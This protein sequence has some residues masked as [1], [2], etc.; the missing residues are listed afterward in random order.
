MERPKSRSIAPSVLRTRQ[1]ASTS[2]G[3]MLRHSLRGSK[4]RSTRPPEFLGSASAGSL[5]LP[6]FAQGNGDGLLVSFLL[7]ELFLRRGEGLALVELG[8]VFR[9]DFFGL[10]W[11]D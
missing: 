5:R 6:F 10:P 3:S 4:S 1:R 7:T 11:F 9:D 2:R 8:Y